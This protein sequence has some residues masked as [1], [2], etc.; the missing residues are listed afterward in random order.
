MAQ[1]LHSD[2]GVNSGPVPVCSSDSDTFGFRS[3]SI[4]LLADNWLSLFLSHRTAV[5][6]RIFE[7]DRAHLIV[8]DVTSRRASSLECY[9]TAL[10]RTRACA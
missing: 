7:L 2:H 4:A 9:I 5:G 3:I 1:V 10:T 8:C 6:R